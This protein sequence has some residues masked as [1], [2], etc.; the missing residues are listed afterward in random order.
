[1]HVADIDVCLCRVWATKDLSVLL[2]CGRPLIYRTVFLSIV[3]SHHFN[4]PLLDLIVPFCCIGSSPS[5]LSSENAS[6]TCAIFHR[7]GESRFVC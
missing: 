5:C 1:M 4:T 2:Q 6:W 7:S 3:V